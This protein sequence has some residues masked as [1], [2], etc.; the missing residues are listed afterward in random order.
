M[1]TKPVTYRISPEVDAE[2]KRLAAI[3][4][5]TDKALRVLLQLERELEK[6]L[7]K[8]FQPEPLEKSPRVVGAIRGKLG[9]KM[10]GG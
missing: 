3:H 2:L 8:H 5:G 4:G 10:K 6:N 1:P 7:G 9:M